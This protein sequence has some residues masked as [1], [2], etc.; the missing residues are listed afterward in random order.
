MVS[1]RTV[2]HLLNRSNVHR[3]KPKI[4]VLRFTLYH[5]YSLDLFTLVSGLL[6]S[7]TVQWDLGTV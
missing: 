1:L 5:F 3:H 2:L 6:L 4:Y 7:G